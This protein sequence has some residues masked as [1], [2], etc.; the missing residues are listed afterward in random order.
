MDLAMSN[1]QRA[2]SYERF[3]S[4]FSSHCS[5]LIARCSIFLEMIKFEHSIFA[6]PFAYLGLLLGTRG[7]PGFRIFLYVTVAM[8]SFRTMGMALNRLIDLKIDAENPR[9]QNRALPA[10]KLKTSFVW[11][12]TLVSFL[13]FEFAAAQLNP[14]CLSLSPIPIFFAILYPFTKRFTWFSHMVLGIILGIA[15]YGAWLAGSREFSWIPAFLSLGVMAWVTGFDIIYALQDLDFDRKHGLHSFPARFGYDKSLLASRILHVLTL[16]AWTVT[17]IFA[18]LGP[19]YF[20]GLV[21]I[22]FFLIREQWLVRSF[23]LQKLEEAF[24]TMNATVSVSIFI[25]S[26]IDLALRSRA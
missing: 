19:F 14:L 17:G 26:L 5:L 8:V 4:L 3:K 15:P 24:F 2:M 11:I 22:S 6:L 10:K 13:I 20:S 12:A 23:G 25:V 9:T 16:A 21:L 18:H 7:W 1:E